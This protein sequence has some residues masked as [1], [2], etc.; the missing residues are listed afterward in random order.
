MTGWVATPIAEANGLTL[1]RLETSD[2]LVSVGDKKVPL[3]KYKV[4]QYAPTDRAAYEAYNDGFAGWDICIDGSLRAYAQPEDY[5]V[6]W[7]W[8]LMHGWNPDDEDEETPYVLKQVWLD[9]SIT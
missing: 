3:W 4:Y 2:K 7:L 6:A 1:A 5:A 9:R 8:G